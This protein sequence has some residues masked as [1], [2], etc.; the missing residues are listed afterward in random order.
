V[1]RRCSC[2]CRSKSC[3]EPHT[4]HFHHQSLF[5]TSEDAWQRLPLTRGTNDK[6]S[7]CRTRLVPYCPA[8]LHALLETFAVR[9]AELGYF[10]QVPNLKFQ[11]HP[12]TRM[13]LNAVMSSMDGMR[14]G[15][16]M[17]HT[18][19]AARS[20]CDL[21]PSQHSEQCTHATS[22]WQADGGRRPS[23]THIKYSSNRQAHKGCMAL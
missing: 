18:R 15:E 4:L 5:C 22:C 2:A 21:H 6:E 20:P 14:I 23:P 17:P 9:A 11:L 16:Q 10:S 7:I 13:H 12:S 19:V 3:L 8:M 1:P